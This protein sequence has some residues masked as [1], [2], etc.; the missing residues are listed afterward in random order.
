MQIAANP[1]VDDVLMSSFEPMLAGGRIGLIG[2]ALGTA[3]WLA[4]KLLRRLK[5]GR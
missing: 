5:V 4:L 3:A 1:S 2:G